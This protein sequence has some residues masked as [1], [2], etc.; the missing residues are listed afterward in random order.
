MVAIASGCTMDAFMSDIF[1]S[2]NQCHCL[3]W[4]VLTLWLN[5]NNFNSSSS[6]YCQNKSIS[7]FFCTMVLKYCCILVW[8]TSNHYLNSLSYMN[9][10]FN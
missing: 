5:G 10:L 8:Q 4:M 2:A 9:Y 1:R 7:L 6:L 3:V